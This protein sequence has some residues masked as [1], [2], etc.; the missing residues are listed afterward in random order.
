LISYGPDPIDQYRRAAGYVDRTLK[1]EK[2]A[3]L[4]V[5]APTRY[6]AVRDAGGRGAVAERGQ[7]RRED[8]F[9]V[10]AENG[11]PEHGVI[12]PAAAPRPARRERG[13]QIADRGLGERDEIDRMAPAVG[14]LAAERGG[15]D[16][17]DRRQHGVGA[18]PADEVCA[19]ERFRGVPAAHG[20]PPAARRCNATLSYE[21]QTTVTGWR[22]LVDGQIISDVIQKSQTPS[23]AVLN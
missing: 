10:F 12:V 2:P 4:P 6:E 11:A 1:G 22:T 13:R 14:F 19:L 15:E 23:P 7:Q 5:Q 20:S 17:H 16:R 3:D 8:R 9:R 18:L 21:T